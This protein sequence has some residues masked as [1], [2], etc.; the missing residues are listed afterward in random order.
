MKRTGSVI[1]KAV[2]CLSF[3]AAALFLPLP[4]FAHHGWGGRPPETFLQG[5]LSGL[6]HPV[7]GLD[8]FLFLLMAGALV[9]S[10]EKPVNHSAAA[11]L[12][13]SGLFGTSLHLAAV[14]LP[15]P[16]VMIAA[17]VIVGGGLVLSRRRLGAASL[18]MLFAVAG[19]F[20]GY[21]YAESI[22][23]VEGTPLVAYLSGL[24]LIQYA[25]V[26]GVPIALNALNDLSEP[27]YVVRGERLAGGTA[28]VGGALFLALDFL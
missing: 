24:V 2:R 5:F 10:L 23:G 12:V 9:R 4:A 25:V 15:T 16:E 11:L 3:A 8:H 14:S 27:P 13:V 28:V 20:H 19:I 6:A 26:A 7:I 17:S 1:S 18:C 22:I 21:A